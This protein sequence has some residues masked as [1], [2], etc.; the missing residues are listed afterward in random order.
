MQA[1][2]SAL[3]EVGRVTR[4]PSGTRLSQQGCAHVAVA[5]HCRLPRVA[6][7]LLGQPSLDQH[8]NG[9][10]LGL[11]NGAEG[12]AAGGRGGRLVER[13]AFRRRSR[14]VALPGH[15][16]IEAVDDLGVQERL[17]RDRQH[18]PC[19]RQRV[20][21]NGVL[22][23]AVHAEYDVEEAIRPWPFPHEG[24]AKLDGRQ[25]GALREGDA[26]ALRHWLHELEAI[27]D[28]GAAEAPLAAVGGVVEA[29]QL[30]L[31]EPLLQL[32]Q[33]AALS[34]ANL[35]NAEGR[36]AGRRVR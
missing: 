14:A 18:A 21:Q 1:D 23:E 2:L 22:C 36:L 15:P 11:C 35:Q 26:P 12:A 34:A 25:P 27:P 9:H 29:V 19:L 13:L 16:A 28:V 6:R 17:A 24:I 8:L 7:G 10:R 32:Q 20:Q 3:Q 31:G 33:R 4:A 30:C 5:P